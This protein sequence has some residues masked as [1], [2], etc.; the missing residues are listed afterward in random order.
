MISLRKEN[1]IPHTGDSTSCSPYGI[2]LFFTSKAMLLCSLSTALESICCAADVLAWPGTDHILSPYHNY[3]SWLRRN[4]PGVALVLPSAPQS[5]GGAAPSR[6]PA[7]P[8]AKSL[9]SMGR[10][11]PA[12]SSKRDAIM[13]IS[14][15][16]VLKERAS[17]NIPKFSLS[18]SCD[19]QLLCVHTPWSANLGMYVCML[20]SYKNPETDSSHD[21]SL[22]SVCHY[23]RYFLDTLNATG[24]K[25]V[26]VNQRVSWCKERGCALRF[27]WQ[28]GCW[29]AM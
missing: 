21:F 27:T 20:C 19:P 24:N 9:R 13:V 29:T 6:T 26:K 2:A 23:Q 7:L 25:T 4:P 5:T 28:K 3:Q 18:E 1:G 22:A 12:W 16:H 17:R 11:F 10:R 8:A 15:I 14:L